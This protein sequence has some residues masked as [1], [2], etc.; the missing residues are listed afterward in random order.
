MTHVFPP[1]PSTTA[2]QSSPARPA[3]KRTNT[4][5]LD[6]VQVRLLTD[7]GQALSNSDLRPMRRSKIRELVICYLRTDSP[8]AD[9]EA[10]FLEYRDPT[11][12][13]AIRNVMR[14][15]S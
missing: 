5:D 9:F 13:R 12:E 15:A 10:Y 1:P 11:G 14:M 8:T 2:T 3:A 6:P 4:V 7:Q